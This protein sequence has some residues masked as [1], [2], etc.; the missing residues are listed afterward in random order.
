VSA[1]VLEQT[2]VDDQLYAA[3]VHNDLVADD[4]ERQTWAS[5]RSGLSAGLQRHATANAS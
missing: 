2:V 4:G 1:D 5:V 3:A